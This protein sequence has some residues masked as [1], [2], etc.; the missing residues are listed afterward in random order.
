[1]SRISPHYDTFQ[2]LR[3]DPTLPLAGSLDGLIQSI[4]FSLV[5][6]RAIIDSHPNTTANVELGSHEEDKYPMLPRHAISKTIKMFLG[7]LSHFDNAILN[8][9]LSLEIC[10]THRKP[11][12]LAPAYAGSKKLCSKKTQIHTLIRSLSRNITLLRSELESFVYWADNVLLASLADC[13]REKPTAEEPTGTTC[14]WSEPLFNSLIDNCVLVAQAGWSIIPQLDRANSFLKKPRRESYLDKYRLVSHHVRKSSRVK[15]NPKLLYR[16]VGSLARRL[17]NRSAQKCR[18]MNYSEDERPILRLIEFLNLHA[19]LKSVQ[20]A[21]RNFQRS[22][23]A[24]I[25]PIPW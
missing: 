3:S 14:V 5:T 22:S 23:S 2:A 8:P 18:S 15:P 11:T 12:N 4:S 17:R 9:V 13:G 6:I 24:Q 7:I 10:S 16:A 20:V 25:T 19:S 1:M 21:I